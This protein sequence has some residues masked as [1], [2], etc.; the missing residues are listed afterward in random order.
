MKNTQNVGE[1]ILFEI[2]YLSYSVR[3]GEGHRTYAEQWFEIKALYVMYMF[4]NSDST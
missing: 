4:I 3:S 2:K 1:I